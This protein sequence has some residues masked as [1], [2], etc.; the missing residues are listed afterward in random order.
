MAIVKQFETLEEA[1]IRISFEKI[2]SLGQEIKTIE[3]NISFFRKDFD[4][5][6]NWSQKKAEE[7]NDLKDQ[8]FEKRI[9][10]SKNV[11]LYS[12][13]KITFYQE[14]GNQKKVAEYQDIKDQHKSF[15]D[16]LNIQTNN[17]N[18]QANKNPH[19]KQEFS[20][21]P[22]ARVTPVEG[23]T[24]SASTS[25]KKSARSKRVRFN[26]EVKEKTYGDNERNQG[27]K[28]LRQVPPNEE[29]RRRAAKLIADGAKPE[30]P[31]LKANKSPTEKEKKA[32][33]YRRVSEEITPSAK[34]PNVFFVRGFASP[35]QQQNNNLEKGLI[36]NLKMISRSLGWS[37]EK[38]SKKLSELKEMLKLRPQFF[39]QE[40]KTTPSPS[41]TSIK[42]EKVQLAKTTFRSSKI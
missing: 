4:K 36:A 37:R 14:L 25:T 13:Y 23:K 42:F 8:L 34:N 30:K 5:K 22:F 35:R 31:I 24:I 29:G 7:L 20:V 27:Q 6:T 28:D 19:T 38:T 1:K 17:L 3:D 18:R 10:Y 41:T 21:T 11:I 32:D 12:D 16:S 39:K 15:L 33:F 26:P 9:D 2:K 40:D